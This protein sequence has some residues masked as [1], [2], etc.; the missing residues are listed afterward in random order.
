VAVRD[1]D[2]GVQRPIKGLHGAIDTLD[3]DRNVIVDTSK[4]IA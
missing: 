3:E 2:V 4:N 1:Q